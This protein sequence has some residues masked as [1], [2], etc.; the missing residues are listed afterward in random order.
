MVACFA[1]LLSAGA[2]GAEE[3][4]GA[5][6]NFRLGAALEV[7]YDDNIVGLSEQDQNF[8]KSSPAVGEDR[9]GVSSA[10]DTALVPELALGF[11]RKPRKGL[12]TGISFVVRSR[13]YL[14]NSVKSY[15]ELALTLRQELN[16]S[17]AHGTR[18]IVGVSH[19]PEYF[20][21]RLIDEDESF[22]AGTT[23]RND[24]DYRL[25]SA[26]V[27]IAQEVVSRVFDLEIGYTRAQRDYNDHFNEKDSTGDV[28]ALELRLYPLRRI[29][30]LVRPYYEWQSRDAAGDQAFSVAVVDDDGGFDSNL[31]GLS[32]RGL[33]GP[34]GDHRNTI[35]VFY[36]RETRNF[37]SQNPLDTGHFGR[38]DDIGKY[39]LSYNRELGPAWELVFSG[40][41][42]LNDVSL[43][44]GSS[45]LYPKTV[46]TATVGYRF[47]KPL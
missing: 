28:A 26:R 46:F 10:A 35:N 30:F 15:Q 42:R 21:R 14:T 18:L 43:S 34:D 2:A 29:G 38:K 20:V 11:A 9:F 12:E 36:E 16:R 5:L 1:A 23:V 45:T 3:R 25:T 22:L 27:A 31:Y 24:V 37:T 40:Y 7:R 8:L 13:Q 32:L 6:W 44:D 41:H 4:D 17:R 39:G 33:W 19:I 47:R